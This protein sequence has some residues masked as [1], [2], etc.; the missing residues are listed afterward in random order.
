MPIKGY[1]DKYLISNYGNIK[2]LSRP[3]YKKNGEIHYIQKEKFLKP[4]LLPIGY[5]Y[6]GLHN[7][8]KMK[9]KTI[10]SLVAEHF[11]ENINKKRTV[12]HK[13]GNKLNNHVSNLEWATDSENIQ[14]AYNTG[15]KKRMSLI[16]F[17]EDGSFIKKMQFDSVSTALNFGFTQ[18]GISKSINKKIKHRGWYFSSVGSK[19]KSEQMNKMA[20]KG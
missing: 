7:N 20:N 13:D 19:E 5:F 1:E 4:S 17:R 6:I 18:R 10:H 12:N 14:H 16:A 11:I 2:T 15:L 3:I 8:G 9:L